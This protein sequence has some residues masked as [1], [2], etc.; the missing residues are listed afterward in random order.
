MDAGETIL[1]RDGVRALTLRAVAAEAGVSHAAPAHHFP[2][3]ENML[4]A[5]AAIGFQKLDAALGRSRATRAASRHSF[6]DDFI[7]A[8]VAFAQSERGLYELMFTVARLDWS[9]PALRQ[10]SLEAYRQLEGAAAQFAAQFGTPTRA[11]LI[12]TEQLIWSLA[13]GYAQLSLGGQIPKP[14]QPRPFTP[15][16]LSKFIR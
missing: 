2:S 5:L 9:D 15:P 16:K 10:A 7:S 14:G 11:R 4:T 12:E 13:H 1:A 8:Y 3:L 6:I